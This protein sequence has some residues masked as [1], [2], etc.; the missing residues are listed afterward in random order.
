M[1]DKIFSCHSHNSQNLHVLCDEYTTVLDECGFSATSSDEINFDDIFEKLV[2][3][4]EWT[5]DSALELLALAK[6]KGSFFLR[7]AAALA[8]AMGIEDAQDET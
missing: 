2:A 5:P 4:C 3:T 1:S 6:T 8:I 7:N